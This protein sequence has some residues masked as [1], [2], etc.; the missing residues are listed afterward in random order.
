MFNRL[1]ISR[2]VLNRISRNS[3][4]MENIF[5][6]VR[7][8]CVFSK[9]LGV[10]PMTLEYNSGKGNFKRKCWDMLLSCF[11]GIFVVV[12]TIYI[13]TYADSPASSSLLLSRAWVLIISFGLAMIFFCWLYQHCKLQNIP[14]FLKT[15]HEFD[16]KVM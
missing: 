1:G 15:L 2:T 10:F 6:T 8:F 14:E 4:T 16:S 5:S 11:F 12:S 13:L 7:S 9:W 3:A